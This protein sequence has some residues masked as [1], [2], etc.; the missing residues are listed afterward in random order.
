MIRLN[1]LLSA[2]RTGTRVECATVDEAIAAFDL[3]SK[4]IIARCSTDEEFLGLTSAILKRSQTA[5]E[6]GI[7]DTAWVWNPAMQLVDG[8]GW[9]LLFEQGQSLTARGQAKQQQ[10][11]AQQMRAMQAALG[12]RMPNGQPRRR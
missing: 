12:G 3:E 4:L 10:A 7:G 11:Q 9:R 1:K 8:E 6:M 2:E 5:V